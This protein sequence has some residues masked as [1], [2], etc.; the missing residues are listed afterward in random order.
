MSKIRLAMIGCGGNSS[1]HARRMNGN[2]DV[3]IVGTCD[4][5]TDIANGYID[6]N[7]SDLSPRPVAYDDIAIMLNETKPDAVVISTP[8][9]LHF[10][11]GM[12][13]LEAG[14]HVLMEKPMVT[15]SE[16]AYILADKVKETGL[17]LTIGYNT[18]CSANFHY[19]REIV[20][21]GYFGKLELVIG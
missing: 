17:I 8:H 6:R 19:I 4:V 7:L 1:G 16:D 9:T 3:Q 2:P 10:E 5:N 13:A 14:C 11:Q 18:P 12:Q 15:S 20:R 21:N